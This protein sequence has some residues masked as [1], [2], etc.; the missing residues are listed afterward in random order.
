MR[1]DKCKGAPPSNEAALTLGGV[2][3]THGNRPTRRSDGGTTNLNVVA[4]GAGTLTYHGR[5]TPS[6]SPTG[7]HYSGATRDIDH[8]R[9]RQQLCGE[10]SMRCDW[11]LRNRHFQ[12]SCCHSHIV[13]RPRSVERRFRGRNTGRHRRPTGSASADSHPTTVWTIQTAS[14]PTGG[15]PQYQQIAN[16]SAS[17]AA[18]FARM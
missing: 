17:V 7:A 16:T 12:R 14:P 9:R 11:W 3:I 13:H 4:T 15:R 1:R 18:A 10:L 8:Y 2:T 6:T 5:R